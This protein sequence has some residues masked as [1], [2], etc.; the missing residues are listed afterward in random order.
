MQRVQ[1]QNVAELTTSS[2]PV[3]ANTISAAYSGDFQYSSS[4]SGTITEQNNTAPSS[5]YDVHQ[6]SLPRAMMRRGAWSWV[7]T[8]TS[9]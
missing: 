5:P 4:L 9:G 1:G 2:L 3:G 8:A 7:A 6:Y